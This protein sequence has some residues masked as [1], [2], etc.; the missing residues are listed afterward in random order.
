[1]NA[2]FTALLCSASYFIVALPLAVFVGRWLKRASI[3]Y[4]PVKE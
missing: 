3:Y 4:P 2:I 1:M